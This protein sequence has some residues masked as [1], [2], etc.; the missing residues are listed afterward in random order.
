MT[1]T[2]LIIIQNTATTSKTGRPDSAAAA[3]TS[4]V[5][6]ASPDSPEDPVA[7]AAEVAGSPAA[8]CA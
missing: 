2:T 4:R 1:V 5:V 8:I 6:R 3:G 7:A